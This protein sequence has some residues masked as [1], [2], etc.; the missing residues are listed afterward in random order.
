MAT[1][2]C[3]NTRDNIRSVAT[4]GDVAAFMP[5]SRICAEAQTRLGSEEAF[6]I[7]DE[8]EQER[9]MGASFNVHGVIRPS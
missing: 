9:N 5:L 1:T 8:L 6:S 3:D 7:L 2:N 4:S